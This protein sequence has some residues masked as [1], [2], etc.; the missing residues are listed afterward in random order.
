MRWRIGHDFR[1][2]KGLGLDD[3]VRV[4]E[5]KEDLG[6]SVAFAEVAYEGTGALAAVDGLAER[7]E[8]VV[9]VIEAA[10]SARFGMPVADGPREGHRLSRVLERAPG[11]ALHRVQPA[12][13]V[14]RHGLPGQVAGLAEGRRT[15]P[16]WSSAS[17]RCP[18]L[19]LT[20]PSPRCVCVLAT[21]SPR[22]S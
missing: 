2:L 4:A 22:R 16:L 19:S 13:I 11:V 8:V 18:C 6:L 7:G 3:T 1:A 10:R 17:R 9:G 14:E 20:H 21:P 15:C 12:G 5:S